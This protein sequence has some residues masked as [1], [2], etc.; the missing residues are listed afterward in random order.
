MTEAEEALAA[1]GGRGL[2]QL[3]KDRENAVF[4]VTLSDGR[5]GAL[6]LHRPGY[7]SIAAIRSELIWT[8]GLANA[9]LPVPRPQSTRSGEL[10]TILSTGRVASL[11]EW[12]PGRPLGE[13]GISLGGTA[14][15]Q[16]ERFRDV[17]A[18][19]ARLHNA[20]DAM[21]LPDDFVR[22]AWDAESLLGEHPLWG[23]FWENSALTSRETSLLQEARRVA[24]ARLDRM[25][26]TADF[27]LIHADLM[28][29]NILID[30]AS[31]R[32]IDFDDSGFGFRLYDL[33]TLMLQNLSEPTYDDLL[34]AAAEG[35]GALRP[36]DPTQV[37]FFVFLRC[38]AS[39]GWAQPRLP[40]GSPQLRS[41]AQRAVFQAELFL[42]RQ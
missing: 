20:T 25:R 37:P 38:L 21:G 39:C 40:P 33:G 2:P 16:I 9:G 7:Q 3:V 1:W 29:E 27:G 30:G 15:R 6:R 14:D 34:A 28:R 41:Y 19:L 11:V 42:R 26:P 18:L 23:R 31:V 10:L 32:V 12:L 17:G 22:P 13:A 35:Y 5:P 4:S 8:E 36:I 24:R